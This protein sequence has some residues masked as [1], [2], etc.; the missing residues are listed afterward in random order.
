M[1]EILRLSLSIMIIFFVFGCSQTPEEAFKEAEELNSIPGYEKFLKKY[2]DSQYVQQAESNLE[3]LRWKDAQTGN[4]IPGY[5]D[6]VTRYPNSQYVSQAQNSIEKLKWIG[7]K[8]YFKNRITIQGSSDSWLVNMM[9]SNIMQSKYIATYEALV[10]D[11]IGDSLKV[12]IKGGRVEM[13][14][15]NGRTSVAQHENFAQAR[16][17]ASQMIGKSYVIEKSKALTSE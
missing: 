4:T 3:N 14:T 10:E 16:S 9:A 2:S 12:I 13:L 11:V 6:F 17:M 5:E 8:I 1:K 15:T 7:K